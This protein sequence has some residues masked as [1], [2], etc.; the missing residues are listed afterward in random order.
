LKNRS[1]IRSA[2][3]ISACTL[4]SRGLGMIRDIIFAYFFG[5]SLMASAF[6]VAFRIPN[7][8]RRLFGEGALS[9]SLIPVLMEERSKKGES[10]AWEL[11][12]K[13][14]SLL[15][16]VLA[17]IALT[18]VGLYSIAAQIPDL[19]AHWSAHFELAQIM[20][21]YV[22]FICMAA[23]VMA[24]LHTYKKFAI[25][26]ITPCLLNLILIIAMLA[27][28]PL[29]A[30][31]GETRIRILCWAVLAAGFAQVAFQ[32]PA[33][34]KL[35]F[36]P[37]FKIDLHDPRIR[38]ILFLM[39]PA[40]LGAGITQINVLID[41][42]LA[43]WIGPH[44]PAALFY[45]ERMIY[46]PLGIIATALG[47]VLLPTFSA[48][49]AENDQEGFRN[50]L[51]DSLRHL[52]FIMLPAAI[53]IFALAPAIL[54]TLFEWGGCF[55]A[56]STDLT[57]LALRC[58]APGLVVFSLSKVF[59]PAFYA[60]KDTRTPVKIGLFTV[61]LNLCLNILFILT[62]PQHIKHAGMAL[63]TVLAEALG[64]LWLGLLLSK[65]IDCIEWSKIRC[66][67]RRCLLAALLMGWAC[68]S[69]LP[70]LSN[71][72]QSFLPR[73]IEQ[74]VATGLA[75]ALGITTYLL[76]AKLFRCIELKEISQALRK[77]GA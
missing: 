42:Y 21:P 32:W 47:T 30:E 16:L 26:A 14:L 24:V 22:L 60:M 35:G 23:A 5:T 19:P 27:L 44:A 7:L 54:S 46:F 76:A 63:A 59:V 43:V 50:T 68:W 25:S 74:I 12:N 45:S 39:G 20:F 56:D 31:T 2:G 34:L 71:L 51:S 18:G 15:L 10:A 11:T 64:M 49:S 1:V 38:R 55:D 69:S 48:H 8:F 4:F 73:K 66:S 40:A 36:K 9:A 41:S 29:A 6:H 37:R 65:R 53:G 13:V 28:F 58:Y 61:A 3:V 72:L 57:T 33:L 62:L 75:V 70:I 77:R 67:F 52:L 17:L